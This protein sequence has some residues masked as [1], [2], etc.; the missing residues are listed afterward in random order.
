MRLQSLVRY[1]ITL[2]FLVSSVPLV[3]LI[4]PGPD[5]PMPEPLQWPMMPA[6][7]L[8]LFV[9]MSGLRRPE[10]LVVALLVCIV[11]DYLLGTVLL[12]RRST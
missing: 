4:R 2:L 10:S 7:V 3:V 9:S 12:P 11:L 1:P 5:T 6:Y 8:T